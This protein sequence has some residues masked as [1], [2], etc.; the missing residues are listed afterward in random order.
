M[1][2]LAHKRLVDKLME[3]YVSWR[4]ACLDVSDAH[5]SWATETGIGATVAFDRYMAALD[6]EESAAEDYAYL[7]R[8]ANQLVSRERDPAHPLGP[9]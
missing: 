7:S 4:E 3:A 5:R 1:N 9:A 2:K 8:R 6:R